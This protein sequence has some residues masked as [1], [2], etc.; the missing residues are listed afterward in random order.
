VA[1][2]EEENSTR[3][4]RM[5]QQS[6]DLLQKRGKAR[7]LGTGKIIIYR[8]GLAADWKKRHV[9]RFGQGEKPLSVRQKE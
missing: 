2:E 5:H 7:I 1:H 8:L 9:P 3:G 6:C 4:K